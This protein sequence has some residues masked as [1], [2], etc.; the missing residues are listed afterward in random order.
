MTLF[1]EIIASAGLLNYN[2]LWTLG[3]CFFF[4][5]SNN[6]NHKKYLKQKIFLTNVQN[7]LLS[8]ISNI[9][10]EETKKLL[11]NFFKNILNHQK[12]QSVKSYQT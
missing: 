7:I 4:N 2:N 3:K 9:K 6:L 12:H 1:K 11:Y 5:V 8:T 10:E